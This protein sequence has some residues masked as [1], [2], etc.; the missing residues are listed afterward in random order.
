MA[1]HKP[2]NYLDNINAVRPLVLWAFSLQQ[3]LFLVNFI[4]LCR[5]PS[6]RAVELRY[7]VVLNRDDLSILYHQSS[8]RLQ[9]LLKYLIQVLILEFVDQY[10]QSAAFHDG[11]AGNHVPLSQPVIGDTILFSCDK[12]LRG[13]TR[14]V[15]QGR[16]CG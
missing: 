15:T 16:T 8:S 1:I 6:T 13:R 7:R 12:N 5:S 3:R 9:H 11:L 4:F 10:P 2:K 14:H